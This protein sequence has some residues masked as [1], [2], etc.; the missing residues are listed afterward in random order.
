[1]VASDPLKEQGPRSLDLL[2]DKE[3]HPGVLVSWCWNE[4]RRRCY[5]VKRFPPQTLLLE[6]DRNRAAI[7]KCTPFLL[8][9]QGR[10]YKMIDFY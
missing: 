9:F 1:M 7:S 8:L 4:S 10:Y 6:E 3:D 2:A 5:Q